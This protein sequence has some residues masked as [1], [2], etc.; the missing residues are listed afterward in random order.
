[1]DWYLL[2]PATDSMIKDVSKAGKGRF[3]G[4]PSYV[5]EHV[6]IQKKGEG[7]ELAEEEVVVIK[8]QQ[9]WTSPKSMFQLMLKTLCFV[10]DKGYRGKQIDSD[11]LSD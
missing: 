5:Y 2:P 10:S 4:D 11:N 6:E 1:M 9:T 3:V 8:A 7:E